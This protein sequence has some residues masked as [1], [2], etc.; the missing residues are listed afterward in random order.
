MRT[1]LQ[2]FLVAVVLSLTLASVA[3]A[4]ES[5][6]GADAPAKATSQGLSHEAQFAIV[7][8]TVTDWAAY[9][10]TQTIREDAQENHAV[11]PEGMKIFHEIR[12]TEGL[13]SLAF[14]K[15]A[16][17]TEHE[18]LYKATVAKMQAYLKEDHD[19]AD[20]N[21]KKMVPVCQQTYAKMA[22]A[23]ALPPEQVQLAQEASAEAVSTLTHD[24]QA[25]LGT[26]Q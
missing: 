13:A 21:T 12:L 14:D 7:C 17:E 25:K 5:P 15:L 22:K 4:A 2:S 11:S 3:N 8:Q 10:I 19:G 26:Q 16:P 23:G 18:S 6:W 24:I 1:F 20:A 9:Q